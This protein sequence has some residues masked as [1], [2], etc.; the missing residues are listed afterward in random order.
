MAISNDSG[1]ACVSC[2]SQRSRVTD[3][4]PSE[5]DE[6]T[7]IRRRRVCLDCETRWSTYELSS[8]TLMQL[9]ALGLAP[10]AAILR[11]MAD[12]MDDFA[13]RAESYAKG[14]EAAGGVQVPDKKPL[15]LT[16]S[17]LFGSANLQSLGEEA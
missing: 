6:H 16:A 15:R 17:A 7:T 12:A 5:I 2:G 3:S 13:S 9:G 8:S 11:G 14:V 1:I 10:T 4:R